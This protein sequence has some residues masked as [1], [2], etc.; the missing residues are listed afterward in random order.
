MGAI[1]PLFSVRIV[2]LHFGL[3]FEGKRIT[4]NQDLSTFTREEGCISVGGFMFQGEVLAFP[5][6]R[7]LIFWWSTLPTL[8]KIYT[9]SKALALMRKTFC[10][11]MDQARKRLWGLGMEI[12][13]L[14][15]SIFLYKLLRLIFLI[16]VVWV[17]LWISCLLYS[18]GHFFI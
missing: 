16:F 3:A 10:S 8:K 5:F 7:G 13:I 17:W 9:E 6:R 11:F 4:T 1:F 18:L 12:T 2:L 15:R 14:M